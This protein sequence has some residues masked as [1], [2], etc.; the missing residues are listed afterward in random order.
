MAMPGSP[1]YS[2]TAASRDH[3]PTTGTPRWVKAF[4]TI[5]VILMLVFVLLHLPGGPGRHELHSTPDHGLH[6]P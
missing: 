3:A 5:T 1:V 6:Q 4:G 2:D